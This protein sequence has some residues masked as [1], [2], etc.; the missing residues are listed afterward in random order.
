MLFYWQNCLIL[1]FFHRKV[2]DRGERIDSLLDKTS[3]LKAESVGSSGT[4][5][6]DV[7][8]FL[9]DPLFSIWNLMIH[10]TMVS[11]RFDDAEATQLAKDE[12]KPPSV[13]RCLP[14]RAT[15]GTRRLVGRVGSSTAICVLNLLRE[16]VFCEVPSSRRYHL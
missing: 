7:G 8:M 15:H 12:L 3:A 4:G 6:G 9:M 14:Q 5:G 16:F 10:P 11:F 2:M 13:E 1:T